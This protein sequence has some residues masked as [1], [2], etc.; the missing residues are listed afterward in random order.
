MK[1]LV[2]KKLKKK[3]KHISSAAYYNAAWSW[4]GL[5]QIAF[6]RWPVDFVCNGENFQT[7]KGTV[8]AFTLL[9][10]FFF[11]M[12]FKHRVESD[13]WLLSNRGQWRFNFLF[14]TDINFISRIFG[15]KS[16]TVLFIDLKFSRQ[17]KHSFFYV[18]FN[19]HESVCVRFKVIM[20]L[21]FAMFIKNERV[22]KKLWK[23][24][25][26]KNYE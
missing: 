24:E 19:F 12:V 16:K 13:V 23:H 15:D 9:V 7:S 18:G 6:K 10:L 3:K 5:C 8:T 4:E 26:L 1:A 2:S 11:L 14:I 25:K 20:E 17:I 22:K 21:K